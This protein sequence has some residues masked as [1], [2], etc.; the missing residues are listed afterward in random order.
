ML[1]QESNCSDGIDNDNDGLIDCYDT[2]CGGTND[3]FN[4][5]YGVPLPD[6]RYIPPADADTFELELV[7]QTDSA[8]Y[9]IDQRHSPIVGDI[10][11]DGIPEVLGKDPGNPGYIRIFNGITGD[12]ERAITVANGLTNF[13]NLAIA[14]V[15]DDGTGEIFAVD[16]NANLLRLEHDGTL[17]WTNTSVA[18]PGERNSPAIAD[19]DQDGVPEVYV[20]NRIYDAISGNNL[21]NGTD[22][23]GAGNEG[24]YSDDES[25]PVAIDVFAST[26]TLPDASAACGKLCNGLELVAGNAVYAIALDTTLLG[27]RM[28]EVS[29]VS[30]TSIGDGVTSVADMD[31]DGDLD[32]V[33]MDN[34]KIYMWDLKSGTQLY[35]TY[36]VTGTGSGGRINLADFDNDGIMEAGV[37]GQNIYVV[38]DTNSLG[39]LISK[40][41]EDTDDGSQRT[42]STVFDFEGDGVN[43]VVY[44]DEEYL[45]VFDGASGDLLSRV[46]SRSG[47][48]FDYP[49]VADGNG[50]GQAEIIITSQGGNGPGFSG[51][52]YLRMY[53]SR[54]KPWVA[55][56]T[57]WNQHTYIATNIND[58]LSVPTV[59]QNHHLVPE[60]NGFLVQSTIRTADGN[61]FFG[62]PDVS[63]I[64]VGVDTSNCGSNEVVFNVKIGNAG[65]WKF[66]INAPVAFYK[67]NPRTSGSTLID[68]TITSATVN[69]QT[70]T[71]ISLM[72]EYESGDLPAEIYIVLNDSGFVDATL[73]IDFAV[74][75]PVTGV[76]EC[77]YLNNYTFAYI[78][79]DCSISLDRD[80]DGISDANDLDSDND[81]IPDS[82]ETGTASFDPTGDADADGIVNYLDEDDNTLNFP[83]F[84]DSNGD[85]INDVYDQDTDGIPDVFDLD[86][87]NDGI[88]DLI[89]AGGTD[90]DGNGQVDCF[91]NVTDASSLTDSDMD[92]WCDTYDNAGGAITSGTNLPFAD[93]DGDGLEDVLDLDSDN[94]GIPDVS[95]AGGVDTDGN[96]LPDKLDDADAD[97]LTDVYDPDDDGTFGS[98]TDETNDPVVLTGPDA[99][100]GTPSGYG[101]DDKDVDSVPN[102]Q[103][104]D[105]DNDGISD[106]IE[107]GGTDSN[108]NGLVDNNTDTDNDGYADTFDSDNGGTAIFITGA[109]IDNDNKPNNYGTQDTDS[110]LIPNF[111]DVDSDN[112]GLLDHMEAQSTASYTAL[113]NT[114][115]DN[116]GVLN[117]FEAGFL[118]PENTDLD[119]DPDYIDLDADG[120]TRP[121]VDEAWDAYDDGDTINDSTCTSDEDKD[122]LLGC[123]D[124]DDNDSTILTVGRTPPND[125]GF[126]GTNY[127]G[128]QTSSGSGL[129]SIFPNNGGSLNEPD[130]RDL[131]GCAL[132]PGLVY[133]IT[134]TDNVYD[135]TNNDH[136]FSSDTTGAIRATDF[137][138]GF[139]ESGW[140]YYFNP[141]NADQVIFSIEQGSNTTLVDYIELRREQPAS[142]KAT[143]GSQ[144]YFVLARDWFVKTVD[145]VSLTANVNVRFYYDPA[146][147]TAMQTLADNFVSST[148]GSKGSVVWFKVDNT[149]QNSDIDPGT[150]LT[151]LPGYIELTPSS[152]GTEGGLHY[153]QFDGISDFS[154]GGA[155]VEVGGTLPVE[156]V[157]FTGEVIDNAVQLRWTTASESQSLAFEIER[158]YQGPDFQAIGRV[159]AA[160][161]SSKNITYD[162][163]DSPFQNREP[164]ALYRLKQIDIDGSIQYSN[165]IE[166]ANPGHNFVES[167]Q[168]YP[169]PTRG[170]INLQYVAESTEKINIRIYAPDGKNTFQQNIFTKKGR[171][172]ISFDLKGYPAGIYLLHVELTGNRKLIKFRVE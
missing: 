90:T 84:S 115:S 158:S 58:D 15:D 85:G 56:R 50:D 21:A 100:D 131:D 156:L 81:G 75:F 104:L 14:D 59:Q 161:N 70:D 53:R 77:N 65:E 8:L 62:A 11:N 167:L 95:E 118:T 87:D 136:M 96:G 42:G 31:N 172:I 154:G 83:V 79:A 133:P 164:T 126:N 32:G 39:S 5:F 159:D 101:D 28:I 68:T 30:G 160:G 132:S 143:S 108:S 148:G 7:W 145:N 2:D 86:S 168:V 105:A 144:G 34:G 55:A 149:W 110:D 163:W 153:V 45:Y 140:K 107:A 6:C 152:F 151:E 51:N 129:A 52:N 18:V 91:S 166:V 97:G 64:I 112:D 137:C 63:A 123:F 89:E 24:G 54:N 114:D 117:A 38:I 36:D 94:D 40:W 16:N 35:D 92:G 88:P 76:G 13:S 23:A 67:G 125:N 127:E 170:K 80:R 98:D 82:Q 46:I 93:T 29:T 106:L 73:P 78:G 130:W 12:Q 116:D 49:L 102:W 47:T 128:S 41:S 141:L 3:C 20:A 9:P 142:R 109:D 146:D 169:V 74:D 134:G 150:G 155:Q 33:I 139:I 25:F 103:D 162:Y 111:L 61:P 60:L 71:T 27:H 72:M 66:P 26:D 121:D 138:D 10:D 122:G 165:V 99:G 48:R 157:S 22:G 17:S 37:A 44:S 119:S 113:V 147:S 135:S 171:H 120:D 69:A 1:S 19:F 57:V 43:E 4:F 124:S